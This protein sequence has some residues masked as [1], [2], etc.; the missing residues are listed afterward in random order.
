MQ[1]HQAPGIWQYIIPIV[2]AGVIW[3]CARDA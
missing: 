2:I 1:V 3:R